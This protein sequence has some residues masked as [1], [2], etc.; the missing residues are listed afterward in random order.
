AQPSSGTILLY[1]DVVPQLSVRERKLL[2]RLPAPLQ[3]EST[4]GL[5]GYRLDADENPSAQDL[6]VQSVT[7]DDFDA[8][9]KKAGG[10]PTV[11]ASRAYRFQR[12][13]QQAGLELDV[14]G[15]TRQAQGLMQWSLE[16]HHADLSAKF[17]FKSNFD[18]LM[19]LE[20]NVDPG[21][22]LTDVVGVDVK[23]WH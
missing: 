22:T 5:V 7:P 14:R 11:T 20:F 4:A 8:L 19:L 13:S 23:R 18:D 16:P 3:A 6:T 12:K 10:A 21:L 17:T 1:L 15:D 2:L 9:W